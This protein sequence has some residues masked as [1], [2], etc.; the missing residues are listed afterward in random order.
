[1]NEREEFLQ[2][3]RSVF[4]T[5]VER[6]DTM[7]ESQVLDG[8]LEVKAARSVY[9]E[10]LTDGIEAMSQ[11]RPLE[12]PRFDWAPHDT[13]EAL[14]HFGSVQSFFSSVHK[15]KTR[16]GARALPGRR[17]PFGS[18]EDALNERLGSLRKRPGGNA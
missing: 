8:L 10:A 13:Q 11:A 16:A 1:M 7:T 9:K 6:L 14:V 15:L 3:F 17:H 5:I 18:L 4:V 2:H 12:R